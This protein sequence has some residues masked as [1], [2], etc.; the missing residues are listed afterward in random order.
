MRNHKKVNRILLLL[1]LP[2]DMKPKLMLD[3]N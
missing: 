2:I 1:G 3:S